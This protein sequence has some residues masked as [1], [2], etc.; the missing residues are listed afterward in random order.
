MID[1][2]YTFDGFAYCTVVSA[3]VKTCRI[4]EASHYMEGMVTSYNAPINLNCKGS[5]LEVACEIL[6]EMDK[7]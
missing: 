4:E 2:G 5:K 3:L 6:D 7:V 1:K